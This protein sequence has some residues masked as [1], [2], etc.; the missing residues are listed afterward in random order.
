MLTHILQPA[1]LITLSLELQLSDNIWQM[2]YVSPV[3][4]HLLASQCHLGDW[5]VTRITHFTLRASVM[6]VQNFNNG[7]VTETSLSNP[8]FSK[9]I[10]QLLCVILLMS[11]TNF[12]NWNSWI[13]DRLLTTR[14]S[15]KLFFIF[16]VMTSVA[17]F[18]K[19]WS[20]AFFTYFH[21]FAMNLFLSVAFSIVWHI[22]SPYKLKSKN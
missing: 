13:L 22:S 19:C 10:L 9:N 16:N 12:L 1:D 14:Y 3:T 8:E 11:Q 2:M 7:C 20:K 6:L 5:Y 21:N 17:M 4:Q 15:N 18:L